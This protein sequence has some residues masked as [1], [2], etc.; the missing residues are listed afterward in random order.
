MRLAL[1]PLARLC[2]AALGSS[3]H[4]TGYEN[5][6]DRVLLTFSGGTVDIASS[7]LVSVEPEENFE[8]IPVP[9]R[10]AIPLM[11]SFIRAAAQKHGWTKSL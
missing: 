5:Q 10:P 7:D 3:L 2:S 11:D 8:P 1:P 9:R 6:G 4:I